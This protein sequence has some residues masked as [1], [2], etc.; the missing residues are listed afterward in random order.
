M[1]ELARSIAD[2][3]L[4]EGIRLKFCEQLR[5]LLGGY[6]QKHADRRG[7]EL[8]RSRTQGFCHCCPKPSL[9]ATVKLLNLFFLQIID[10]VDGQCLPEI[11]PARPPA[12][13]AASRSL[14]CRTT[15][16][17]LPAAPP[18]TLCVVSGPAWCSVCLATV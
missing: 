16:V 6:W 14:C 10:L 3:M 15:V 1:I 13:S 18:P 9:I 7:I 8:E 5:L 11:L 2:R 17:A 4:K 12:A